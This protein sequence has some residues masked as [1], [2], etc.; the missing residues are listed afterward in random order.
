MKKYKIPFLLLLSSAVMISGCSV[1]RQP[2]NAYS[3]FGSD[4][5][6]GHNPVAK[7]FNEPETNGFADLN[8]V[9]LSKKY[10][11][12]TREVATIEQQKG[13]LLAENHRLKEQNT[14]L[15]TKLQQAEKEL[16]Q[17]NELLRK[18]VIELNNW[19][20]SVIGFREEMRGA[21]KAQ[22]EALLKILK[23]L[24]GKTKSETVQQIG[25][26]TPSPAPAASEQT[27]KSV[28]I[29]PKQSTNTG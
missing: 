7:R 19:K 28:E 13:N 14:S 1:P 26:D 20:V 23:I 27:E 16:S 4:G 2:V 3:S 10:A 24:G 17:A 9:E 8:P 18:M 21:D 25:P 6:D 11:K 29:E 15:Q 22:L 12:L 5:S